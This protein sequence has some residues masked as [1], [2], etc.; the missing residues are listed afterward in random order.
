LFSG[1]GNDASSWAKVAEGKP[2][3]SRPAALTFWYEYDAY[4]D[5]DMFSA[6]IIIKTQDGTVLA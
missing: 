5:T 2:L 3:S 1:R 4:T 6:E